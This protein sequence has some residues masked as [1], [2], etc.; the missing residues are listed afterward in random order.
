MIGSVFECRR[1]E[2]RFC[3]FVSNHFCMYRIYSKLL[4]LLFKQPF[5]HLSLTKDTFGRCVLGVFYTLAYPS[6]KPLPYSELRV[7]TPFS[8]GLRV[9]VMMKFENPKNGSDLITNF[10]YPSK[11]IQAYVYPYQLP[12]INKS[13]RLCI[14]R[15][16][17]ECRSTRSQ[18]PSRN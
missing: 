3:I 16:F 13:K 10:T 17:H 8:K 9:W 1:R 14:S 6:W 4:K 7:N 5:C 2:M 15:G 12:D 11:L 18:T